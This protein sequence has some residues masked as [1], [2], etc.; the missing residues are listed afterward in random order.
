MA[1]RAPQEPDDKNRIQSYRRMMDVLQCFS[2]TARRLTPSISANAACVNLSFVRMV[3][4][5][6]PKA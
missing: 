1:T 5:S 2:A 4:I 3:S 6:C